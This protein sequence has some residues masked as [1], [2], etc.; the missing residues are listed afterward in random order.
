MGTCANPSEPSAEIQAFIDAADRLV[1]LL[2]T[3]VPPGPAAARNLQAQIDAA[4]NAYDAA[5]LAIAGDPAED[6]EA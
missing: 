5:R 3:K 6:T 2:A 1:N 4:Y